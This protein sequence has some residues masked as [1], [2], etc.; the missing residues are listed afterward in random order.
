MASNLGESFSFIT[1]L[2]LRIPIT[3]KIAKPLWMASFYL[4][5]YW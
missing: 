4:F 5:F 1:T 3:N 2:L